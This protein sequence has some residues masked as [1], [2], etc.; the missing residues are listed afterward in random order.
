MM[1]QRKVRMGTDADLGVSTKLA[2]KM[3]K[4][5]KTLDREFES[6]FN[7]TNLMRAQVPS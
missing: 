1:T 2:E 4:R 3:M 5:V 6:K 7:P